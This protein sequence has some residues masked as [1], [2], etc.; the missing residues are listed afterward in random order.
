MSSRSQRGRENL[1]SGRYNIRSGERSQLDPREIA[2]RARRL[3]LAVLPNLG[4]GNSW[5]YDRC[6]TGDLRATIAFGVPDCMKA[7][8]AIATE[9]YYRYRQ[10]RVYQSV[11]GARGAANGP[12]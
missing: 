10:S 7:R 9:Y 8:E 11:P 3:A 6:F 2:L 12:A 4:K 5:I 1:Q